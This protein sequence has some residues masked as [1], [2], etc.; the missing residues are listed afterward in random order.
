MY[1]TSI[2][3]PRGSFGGFLDILTS[4]LR[5]RDAGGTHLREM[6]SGQC[7]LGFGWR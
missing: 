5:D 3:D 7:D 1:D 4:A 6:G 2:T